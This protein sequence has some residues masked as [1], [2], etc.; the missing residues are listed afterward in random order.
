MEVSSLGFE[1]KTNES[2]W[3]QVLV[4]VGAGVGVTPFLSLLS[5][6]IAQLL[7]SPEKCAL[8]EAHFYWITRDPCGSAASVGLWVWPIF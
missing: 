8:V 3:V 5:T 1:T 6:L 2:P 7:T 4:A